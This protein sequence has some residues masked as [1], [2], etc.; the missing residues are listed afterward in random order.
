MERAEEWAKRLGTTVI[1]EE[2]YLQL[3]D[4]RVRPDMMG[5]SVIAIDAMSPSEV[6]ATVAERLGVGEGLVGVL[7][8]SIGHADIL[9]DIMALDP[10]LRREWEMKPSDGHREKTRLVFIKPDPHP[11]LDD[12]SAVT[13]TPEDAIA[14]AK[15]RYVSRA[16]GPIIDVKAALMTAQEAY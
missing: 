9:A 10:P 7:A 14:L 12:P 4:R 2:A 13:F 3:R 5:W 15:E 11:E 6:D 8:P 16:V 1:S